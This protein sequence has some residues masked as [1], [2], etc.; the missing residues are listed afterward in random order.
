MPGS[1][2]P[3][4]RHSCAHSTSVQGTL[5]YSQGRVEGWLG[6]RRSLTE[7]SLFHGPSHDIRV[8]YVDGYALSARTT[9]PGAHCGAAVA[10][11]PS[12]HARS[13]R[14]D[15]TW[16]C[17]IVTVRLCAPPPMRFTRDTGCGRC[18][19]PWTCPD[20]SRRR[21]ARTGRRCRHRAARLQCGGW[22]VAPFLELQ[23]RTA[24][25]SSTSTAGRRCVWC[26]RWRRP[27]SAADAVA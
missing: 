1:F 13:Q 15:S 24:T 18:R 2:H 19:S 22:H 9:A 11:R 26:K 25:R 3:W 7:L 8:P 6:R 17:W 20:G 5:L 4:L 16:C 14:R 27:W 10:S 12:T 23:P 21:A